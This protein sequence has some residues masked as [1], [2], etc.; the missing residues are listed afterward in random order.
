MRS[1]LLALALA[2]LPPAPALAQAV[3]VVFEAPWTD[4]APEIDAAGDRVV[5]AGLGLP[6]ERLGRLAARR[7]AARRAG[8]DRARALI[9]AW[10]DDA[11]ARVAAS[12]SVAAAVHRAIDEHATVGRVRALSDGGAVVEVTV[13]LDALRAA[14]PMGGLPWSR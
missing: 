4:R 3:P 5:A 7:A 6:D 10:A 13:P 1:A 14:A 9:H 8:E 2:S 12:A 11:L